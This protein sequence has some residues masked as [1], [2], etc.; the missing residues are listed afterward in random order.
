MRK[1]VALCGAVLCFS[2]VAAAQDSAPTLAA[3]SPESAA[4]GGPASAAASPARPSYN[5]YFVWQVGVSYEYTRFRAPGGSF[6]MNGISTSA[7]RSLNSWFG[8][9]GDVT[10]GFGTISNGITFGP[11]PP[12]LNPAAKMIFY[13]GGPHLTRRNDS[14]IELWVHGLAGGTHFRF[15]Q[16]G[17]PGTANAFG[18]VAGGGADLKLSPRFYLRLQGDYLATRF[19]SAFQHSF[20]VKTGFVFNF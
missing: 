12:N 19:F 9:E 11:I 7:T 5:E 2:G 15:T 17:G 10:A 8:L 13:G 18:L 4:G 14:R 20:Q 1:F 6:Q 3:S 16:G